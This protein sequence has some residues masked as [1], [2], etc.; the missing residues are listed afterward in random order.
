MS[1]SRGLGRVL[2][3][4]LKAEYPRTSTA[5]ASGRSSLAAQRLTER[6]IEQFGFD[7]EGSTRQVEWDSD[8]SGFGVR[9]YAPGRKSYVL[10]L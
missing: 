6:R 1:V 8:L 2:L 9:L 4:Y 3:G 5:G 10:S 7:P